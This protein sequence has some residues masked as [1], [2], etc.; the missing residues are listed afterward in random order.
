MNRHPLPLQWHWEP[1]SLPTMEILSPRHLSQEAGPQQDHGLKASA[2]G[3]EGEIHNPILDL[4]CLLVTR[5]GGV[6]S[7][8][9]K[10]SESK[11]ATQ[12]EDYSAFIQETPPAIILL[13]RCST[14]TYRSASEP[15]ASKSGLNM[16]HH[17]E[18]SLAAGG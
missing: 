8:K 3:K 15:L 4:P 1:I 5:M 2:P 11:R 9:H 10:D 7:L 16:A 14:N 13:C 17:E 6:W 12:I 18:R